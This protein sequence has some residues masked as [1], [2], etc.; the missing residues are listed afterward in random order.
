MAREYGLV[1]NER[2]AQTLMARAR[3]TFV[4]ERVRSVKHEGD[5]SRVELEDGSTL[6][7][8]V[9]VDA[10]GVGRF[11]ARPRGRRVY[12]TSGPRI[13]L[14]A[15]LGEY[16]MGERIPRPESDG[17]TG[18]LF[19]QVYGVAPLERVDLV[20]SGEVVDSAPIGERLEV[21]LQRTVEDLASGE[22]V[23][24]RAVQVDGGTAWSSPI[25][26]E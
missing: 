8:S 3:P 12:A 4:S 23:Y 17:Y 25:Y 15:A 20:R 21:T 6:V 24:V 19:V 11:V 13:L 22:Y 7:T 10:T 14:R 1:D 26:V 18:E 5:R 9:F 2:L 16:R